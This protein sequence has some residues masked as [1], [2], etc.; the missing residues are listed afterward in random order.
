VDDIDE[1][2]ARL[3]READ[4]LTVRPD[5]RDRLYRLLHEV[6]Q[7]EHGFKVLRGKDR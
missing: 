3:H 5:E 4:G 1:H 6:G 7:V 2:A